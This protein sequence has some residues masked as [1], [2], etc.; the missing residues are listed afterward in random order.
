MTP[1]RAVFYQIIVNGA[2]DPS[3][4]DWL[5][6]FKLTTA[7]TED[8]TRTTIL[9]GPIRDQAALRGTLTKIWDL[10]LEVLA[11]YQSQYTCDLTQSGGHQN[12]MGGENEP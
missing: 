11:F 8:G 12:T 5:S 7:T 4:S 2:L 3:W 9:T 10:N 6:G 1:E